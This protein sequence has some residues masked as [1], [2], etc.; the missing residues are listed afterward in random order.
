ME[1]ST[2]NSLTKGMIGWFNMNACLDPS[3]NLPNH[4]VIAAIIQTHPFL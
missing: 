1:N 3:F 2:V 4:S